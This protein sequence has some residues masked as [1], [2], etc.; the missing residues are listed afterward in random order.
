MPSTGDSLSYQSYYFATQCRSDIKV[1]KYYPVFRVSIIPISSSITKKRKGSKRST[2]YL[3]VSHVQSL[4][5]Y[6]V[7]YFMKIKSYMLY[8]VIFHTYLLI[9]QISTSSTTIIRQSKE[10]IYYQTHS[11]QYYTLSPD[12][13][14]LEFSWLFLDEN[15][16]I[17]FPFVFQILFH[18][19]LLYSFCMNPTTS[20]DNKKSI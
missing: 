5:T 6:W 8:V 1:I 13:F 15:P 14:H 4:I 19:L 16:I 11:T 10:I 17:E 3:I 9:F 12:N 2:G 20:Q 18:S 7:T